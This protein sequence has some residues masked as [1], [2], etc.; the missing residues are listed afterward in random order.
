[1]IKPHITAKRQQTELL[2]IRGEEKVNEKKGKKVRVTKKMKKKRRRENERK[3]ED[4]KGRKI[5][6]VAIPKYPL[7]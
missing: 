7:V 3:R 5:T 2:G 4:I 6:L 1:M